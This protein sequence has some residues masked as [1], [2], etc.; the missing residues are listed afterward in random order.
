MPMFERKGTMMQRV[1]RNQTLG[2][3]LGPDGSLFD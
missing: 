3:T 1:S 2:E